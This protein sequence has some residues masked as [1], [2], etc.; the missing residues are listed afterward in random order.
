MDKNIDIPKYFRPSLLRFTLFSLLTMGFYPVYWAY[1]N[2]DAIKVFDKS[3]TLPFWR[4]VLFA[5]FIVP[6]FIRMLK[7]IKG[8]KDS[9]YWIVVGLAA[10]YSFAFLIFI[11]IDMVDLLLLFRGNSINNDS[12]WITISSIIGP[13]I[14]LIFQILVY[15]NNKE[16]VPVNRKITRGELIITTV[17]VLFE[18]YSNKHYVINPII[19]NYYPEYY[20]QLQKEKSYNLQ[21]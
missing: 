9:L 13:I 16:S 8:R 10:I 4:A 21:K 1:R 19:K 14:V 7:D 2:W 18:I 6:L 11:T 12:S 5:I 17:I 3:D 20:Q 15:R